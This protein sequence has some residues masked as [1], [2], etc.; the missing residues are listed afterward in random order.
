MLGG[1]PLRPLG[2]GLPLLPGRF[3]HSPVVNDSNREN[4]GPNGAVASCAL[5]KSFEITNAPAPAAV[6]CIALRREIFCVLI[7]L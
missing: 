4:C 1:A 3:H 7:G 5:R 6:S 2:A